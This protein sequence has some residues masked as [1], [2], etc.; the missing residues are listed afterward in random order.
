ME[1]FETAG[2]SSTTCATTSARRR[3]WPTA[4]P[5]KAKELHAKLV[6]WRQHVQAPMPRA[7]TAEERKD[8]AP[9][10]SKR[11]KAGKPQGQTAR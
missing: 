1:F 4:M 11:K 8:Q 3:T 7:R 5:E 9:P 2:S 6:A 10:T